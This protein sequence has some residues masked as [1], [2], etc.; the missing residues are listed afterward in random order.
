MMGNMP[1]Y[2]LSQ[3]TLAAYALSMTSS[4]CHRVALLCFD[5]LGGVTSKLEVCLRVD[6]DFA[7][8]LTSKYGATQMMGNMP[9]YLLS[10]EIFFEDT[11]RAKKWFARSINAARTKAKLKGGSA[12]Q[13]KSSATRKKKSTVRGKATKSASKRKAANISRS[14]SRWKVAKK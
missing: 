7:H 13:N 14:K 2:L 12:L 9:Y 4:K 8:D 11:T 5:I 1:Y 6:K 3:E 10:Q